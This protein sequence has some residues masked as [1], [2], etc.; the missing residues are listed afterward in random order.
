MK[1]PFKYIVA[2]HAYK[3]AINLYYPLI[4][5]EEDEILSNSCEIQGGWG[6]GRLKWLGLNLNP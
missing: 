2:E 4:K 6:V 1:S 3:Y 5:N